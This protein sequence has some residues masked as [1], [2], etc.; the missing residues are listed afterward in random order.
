ME[1]KKKKPKKKKKKT[2]P[3]N[4]KT[5]KPNQALNFKKNKNRQTKQN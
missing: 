3:Q 1:D 4:L 2:P 5:Q